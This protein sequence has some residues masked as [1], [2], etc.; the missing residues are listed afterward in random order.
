MSCQQAGQ[1]L[2]HALAAQRVCMEGSQLLLH[3]LPLAQRRHRRSGHKLFSMRCKAMLP[4]TKPACWSPTKQQDRCAMWVPLRRH[5]LALAT[6]SPPSTHPPTQPATHHPPK[7]PGMQN[8]RSSI[9]TAS[10]PHPPTQQHP[11]PPFSPTRAAGQA[12]H[13]LQ[14]SHRQAAAA[15]EDLRPG[16]LCAADADVQPAN[17]D[18]E[19]KMN[20]FKTKK[21]IFLK[22]LS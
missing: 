15:P 4:S 12:E 1:V 19:K 10:S 20:P 7:Q 9:L 5:P 6:I 17:M 18:T 22:L 11:T 21:E 13:P 2:Q 3:A 8:T 14:H 16:Q